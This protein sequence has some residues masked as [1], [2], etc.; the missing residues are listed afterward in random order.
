M[1]SAETFWRL[2]HNIT[3]HD[4]DGSI[5]LGYRKFR[6][7]FGASPS[8]CAAAYDKLSHVRPV[9]SRPEHLLWTLLHL[10]HYATEHI[11][12]ALVGVSK[13]KHF[14]SGVIFSLIFSQ[15]CQWYKTTFILLG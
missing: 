14:G 7:F 13:K 4:M 12:A 5:A 6:S 9:K 10:K 1:A 3:R 2:G 8:V 15:K 11:S